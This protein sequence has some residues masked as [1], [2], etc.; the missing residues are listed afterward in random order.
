MFI[1]KQVVMCWLFSDWNHKDIGTLYFLFATWSGILGRSISIFIRIELRQPGV[2]I[3]DDNIYNTLVTAHALYYNFF[4]GY[5]IIIGGFGNWL[6]P[7]KLIAPDMAFPR[8]K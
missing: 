2:L 3:G 7:L 4:Y 1:I 6:V 8:I 5:A